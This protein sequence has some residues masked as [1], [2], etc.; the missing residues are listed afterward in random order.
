MNPNVLAA[1][2][3]LAASSLSLAAHAQNGA[4]VID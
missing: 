4:Q 2:T 3:I 1:L